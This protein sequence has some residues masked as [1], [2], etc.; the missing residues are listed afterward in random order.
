MIVLAS[1]ATDV[2]KSTITRE[3]NLTC[4]KGVGMNREMC[5]C[6]CVCVC[7]CRGHDKR[8]T[9]LLL[10]CYPGSANTNQNAGVHRK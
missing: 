3:I 4:G 8:P 7:V 10:D 6:V 2:I 1:P 5:V 9:I